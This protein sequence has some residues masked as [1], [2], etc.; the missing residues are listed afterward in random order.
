MPHRREPDK[1]P[2]KPGPHCISFVACERVIENRDDRT[3]TVVQIIDRMAVSGVVDAEITEPLAG[4]VMP[5]PPALA[6]FTL[7]IVLRGFPEHL[8]S[9]LTIQPYDFNLDPIGTRSALEYER[10]GPL[11]GCN[12]RF[13]TTLTFQE[14]GIYWW[15][16]KFGDREIARLPIEL[17]NEVAV[18]RVIEAFE[19]EER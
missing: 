4:R 18:G 2:A 16:L 10:G 7:V 17:V 3:L 19:T 5:Q 8:N 1:L 14:S 12:I 15:V 9:P 6:A 13:Q 11:R